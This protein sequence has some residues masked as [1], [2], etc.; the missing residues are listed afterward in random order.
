MKLRFTIAMIAALGGLALPAAAGAS[1]SEGY[2][3]KAFSGHSIEYL[4]KPAAG[5][6]VD[7][8]VTQHGPKITKVT[9]FGAVLLAHCAL[10]ED[11]IAG[12]LPT[13][14][15]KVSKSGTFSATAQ[16]QSEL[17][18]TQLQVSVHGHF[19]DK[20]RKAAGTVSLSGAYNGQTGCTTGAVSFS[21]D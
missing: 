3:G 8:Y 7:F 10:G 1:G 14:T 18:E 15:I 17:P 20:G 9:E 13:T 6:S 19:V 16:S 4:G 2:V 12:A 11:R 5:E 21:A